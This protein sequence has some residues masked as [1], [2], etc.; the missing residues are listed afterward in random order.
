MNNG[1]PMSFFHLCLSLS[2]ASPHSPA[3]AATAAL[4][5]AEAE[6]EAEAGG[7]T[8]GSSAPVS[9]MMGAL[10]SSAV[11]ASRRVAPDRPT[12]RPTYLV[13][14]EEEVE[15]A[16]ARVHREAADEK[17][18]DL[19]VLRCVAWLGERTMLRRL[20]V[21]GA[22]RLLHGRSLRL[23]THGKT[24]ARMKRAQL[25][26]HTRSHTRTGGGLGRAVTHTQAHRQSVG[27]SARRTDARAHSD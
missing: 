21:A 6:A 25:H 16:R 23:Q 18:S 9:R 14:P 17:G 20:L 13:G 19:R 22:A 12:D 8:K 5:V 15:L 27:R 2:G 7:R 3:A 11:G 10:M 24:D 4:A 26:A 1:L